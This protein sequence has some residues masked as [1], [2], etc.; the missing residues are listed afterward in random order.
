MSE[1]R[2]TERR[3]R[4]LAQ[5][6][7]ARAQL[8]LPEEVYRALVRLAAGGQQRPDGGVEGGHTDSAGALS[9]AERGTLLAALRARG[10]RPRPPRRG[11]RVRQTRAAA[12]REG[13]AAKVRALLLDGGYSDAY[14]DAIAARR[15]GVA[16]WVWLDYA[17]LTTLMQMLQIH[18]RRCGRTEGR[19]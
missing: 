1:P 9:A 17:G 12:P 13:M 18:A 16:R 8:G 2:T 6:H 11:P 7:L 3:A 19:A 10:W 15:L 4:E 14:A 5:I